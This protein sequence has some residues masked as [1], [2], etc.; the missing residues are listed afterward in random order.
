MTPGHAAQ[1]RYKAAHPE[2]V[3]D[4]ALRRTYGIS[5]EQY[6]EML[7]AQGGVCAI[8]QSP[9]TKTRK[10]TVLALSVDHDHATGRVRALLCCA[11]NRT[12]GLHDDDP[13]VF[14]RMAEYLRR[15][16]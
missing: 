7:D 2:R 15:F 16:D 5:F 8:C 10:G 11:C 13:E 6:N 3:K 12:L 9:E 1:E 4:Q 14:D